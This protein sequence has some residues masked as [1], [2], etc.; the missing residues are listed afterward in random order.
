MANC[1][2]FS[3]FKHLQVNLIYP[4][5][6]FVEIDPEQ[7]WKSIIKTIEDAVKGVHLKE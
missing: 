6:G 7:L 2:I 3:I 5:P 1:G 4:K